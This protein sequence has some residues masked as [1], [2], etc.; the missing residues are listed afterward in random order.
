MSVYSPADTAVAVVT[1]VTVSVCVLYYWDV[2]FVCLLFVK[3]DVV[4]IA[5]CRVQYGKCFSSFLY[6]KI[7]KS[8]HTNEMIEKCEKHAI[9]LLLLQ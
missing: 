2:V 6:F 4:V 8:F 5:R 9:Y 3:R 7:I 1:I